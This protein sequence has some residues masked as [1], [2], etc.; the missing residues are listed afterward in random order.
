VTW[1]TNVDNYSV[2]TC[3]MRK[4]APISPCL[5]PSSFQQQLSRMESPPRPS[6]SSPRVS[7]HASPMP[8]PL[9]SHMLMVLRRRCGRRPTRQRRPFAVAR[10]CIQSSSQL[11][12]RT[13]VQVALVLFMA[14]APLTSFHLV[15]GRIWPRNSSTHHVAYV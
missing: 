15:D 5:I 6:W 11:R 12:Y 7:A 13:V 9:C 1:Q 3:V 10:G 14:R 2:Q 4:R 8:P